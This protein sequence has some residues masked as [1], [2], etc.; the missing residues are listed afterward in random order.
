MTEP[1][2]QPAVANPPS[3]PFPRQSRSYGSLIAAAAVWGAAIVALLVLTDWQFYIQ[4]LVAGSATTLLFFLL[5]KI[6][7]KRFRR[8]IPELV[9]LAL[10]LAGGV[11]GAW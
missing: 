4:W 7:E 6:Q 2:T 3:S 8:R 9:L 1:V 10:S 11:V 5:D